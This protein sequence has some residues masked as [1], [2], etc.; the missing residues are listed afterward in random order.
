M[1]CFS[2]VNS[3]IGDFWH[4]RGMMD[5]GLMSHGRFAGATLQIKGYEKRSAG[6]GSAWSAG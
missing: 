6:F 5:T 1:R 2:I 4:F 3:T